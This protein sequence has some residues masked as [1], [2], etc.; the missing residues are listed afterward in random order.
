MRFKHTVE[1]ALDGLLTNKS[2]TLLTILGIVIGIASIIVIMA[3]GN[4][5]QSL[6]LGQISNLGAETAVLQP[7]SEGGDITEALLSRSITMQ[8]YEAITRSQNVPNLAE[9]MPVVAVSSRVVYRDQTHTPTIIGG[10]ADFFIET[11]EIFPETGTAFQE[12][13][14]DANARVAMIGIDVKE[15]LFGVSPA[16]GKSIEIKGEKFRVVGVFPP[17]GQIAFFNIDD[18]VVIPYTSA[19]LYLTGESNLTEIVMKADDPA[20]IDKLVYDVEATIRETHDIGPGE[21]DDFVVRTQEALLDQI[22]TVVTILTA[23]LSAIVAISLVVGGIGIMNIMLVSVTERTKEIG[24]RKALGA[25]KRDIL[26]Q[27]LYEAM[28]LT[29]T[30]GIIGVMLGA[31]IAWAASLA[32]SAYVI[33]GWTFVFPLWGAVLGVGVS[34]AIGLLFGI[35]PARQASQKSPIEALRYE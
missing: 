16:V 29:V 34:S 27:F 31:L 23:F 6:I 11:F 15:E 1:T 21:E 13:D 30:G 3:L 8:D 14:V 26:R 24:L 7:G 12:S 32:L 18:L 35:Y 4:G 33:D 28:M 2:R 19:Q 5:A 17:K 20:N 25:T 10:K 22:S 9:A